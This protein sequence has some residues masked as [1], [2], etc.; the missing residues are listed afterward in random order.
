[1][2]P[3]IGRAKASFERLATLPL[4]KGR[5]GKLNPKQ[6]QLTSNATTNLPFRNRLRT[7]VSRL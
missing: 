3:C 2:L 7:Y 5:T 6:K 4:Y 1:M